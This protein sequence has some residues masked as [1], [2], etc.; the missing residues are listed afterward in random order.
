MNTTARRS[1][2][3]IYTEQIV[4]LQNKFNSLK[5]EAPVGEDFIAGFG[6]WKMYELKEKVES[7]K[8]QLEDFDLKKE[9]EAY[10]A[11][12]GKGLYAKM[13]K[14]MSAD[15]KSM[16]R[17]LKKL[18]KLAKSVIKGTHWEIDTTDMG[19][20]YARITLCNKDEEGQKVF[21]SQVELRYKAEYNEEGAVNG[22]LHC[23]TGSMGDF[24]VLTEDANSRAQYYIALGQL[25][26]NKEL[27][28]KVADESK[29]MLE[30]YRKARRSYWKCSSVL[31]NPFKNKIEEE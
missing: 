27:M 23:N 22:E 25:L 20:D 21:G 2:K 24:E 11:G 28:Q 13:Q 4:E 15:E 18:D 31:E 30:V 12:E 3:E 6:T 10:F 1:A 7:L 26:A 29:A 16:E 9:I 14:C 8:K 19:Y 5:G 17:M